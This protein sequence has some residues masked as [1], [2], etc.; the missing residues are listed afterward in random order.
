M[1]VNDLLDA[2]R[3]NEKPFQLYRFQ[4]PEAKLKNRKVEKDW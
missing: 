2:A 3:E 4:L 1:Q